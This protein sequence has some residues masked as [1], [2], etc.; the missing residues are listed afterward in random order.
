MDLKQLRTFQQIVASGSFSAASSVL[1]IAQSALSRQILALEKELRVTL[2]HRT[3]RG[4]SLTPAGEELAGGAA[5]LL[6]Q[7]DDVRRSVMRFR[8]TMAGEAT[9][10]LTP[11]V[12]RVLTLPL[13]QLVRDRFPNV[14]LRVMEGYSGTMLEWLHSGRIDAALLY[15]DPR[16]STILA[17][18]VV[19]EN[20]AVI[21]LPTSRSDDSPVATADLGDWPLILPTPHHGLRKLVAAH[22]AAA[23]VTLDVAFEIDALHSTIEAVRA[24]LGRTILPAAAVRAE[25]A[26]GQLAAWRI[27]AP[28]LMRTLIVATSGQRGDAMTTRELSRLLR[29]AILGVAP[30][31]GWRPF[32]QA[33]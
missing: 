13:T 16:V 28:S 31:A 14:R 22:A 29:E 7:A 12:G 33:D 21:G 5:A 3:G 27:A 15:D 25:I 19:E 32:A 11:T 9:V 20:L 26:A 1:H 6:A 17:D 23:G 2:F 24:G 10:G 8:A 18:P 30:V 4:I